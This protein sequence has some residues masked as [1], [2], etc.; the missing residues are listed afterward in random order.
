MEEGSPTEYR[1]WAP[2]R[3]LAADVGC[4]WRGHIDRTGVPYTDRVLPDGCVDLIWDGARLFVAGPDTRPV[5][6][7]AERNRTFVGLRMRTGRAAALLGRPAS[8]IRD[9]RVA[10]ADLWGETSAAALTDEVAG[11]D[12]RTVV[13]ALERAVRSRVE[14]APPA[15]RAVE[16]LVAA[17]NARTCNAPGL[18]RSLAGDLGVTARSLHRRCLAAVGYGPKTLDRVLRFRRLQTLAR[19]HATLGLGELAAAAGYADQAHLTRECR[20]L[21]G[22]TPSKLFLKPRSPPDAS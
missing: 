22:L 12:T 20:R 7:P 5:P 3:D 11:A 2:S 9:R 8:E 16:G 6:L 13:A 18:V 21:S 15:D 4:V 17:L 1:E 10:L 14:A 19:A